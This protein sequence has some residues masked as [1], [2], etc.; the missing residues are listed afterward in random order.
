MLSLKDYAERDALGLA[1]LVRGKEVS[2]AE[3]IETALQAIDKLNPRLNAVVKV[4][5]AEARAEVAEQSR[6]AAFTGVPLLLKGTS[7]NSS[8]SGVVDLESG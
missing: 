5:A 6:G 2:P 7:K 4:M 3:I 8:F 1:E